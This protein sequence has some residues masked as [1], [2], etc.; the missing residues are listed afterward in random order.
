MLAPEIGEAVGFSG[1]LPNRRGK[2][3][4][5]KQADTSIP[6]QPRRIARRVARWVAIECGSISWA[7]P[8]A[9]FRFII[10]TAASLSSF[11]L[12]DSQNRSKSN[13]PM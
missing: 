8:A 13:A 6:P 1:L 10:A 2:A 9:D 5:P 7:G 11:E 3:G 12:I 4:A